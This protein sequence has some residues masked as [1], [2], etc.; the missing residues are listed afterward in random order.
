MHQ[1]DFRLTA[2]QNLIIGSVVERQR[3]QIESIAAEHNLSDGSGRSALR[4][5]AMAC[6]ALPMCG[7]AMAEAER[8]LPQFLTRLE[9]IMSEAGL[10][11]DELVVRITGLPQRVCPAVCRRDRSGRQSLGPVQPLP[12]R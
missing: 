9:Q 2:N 6:V 10:A 4:R 7:R 1:G 3:P 12:G 11:E 8:Y 5:N